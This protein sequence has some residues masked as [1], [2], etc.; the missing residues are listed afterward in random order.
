MG[1]YTNRI[2]ALSQAIAQRTLNQ[3][4]VVASQQ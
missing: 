3:V 1:K 2:E 4:E